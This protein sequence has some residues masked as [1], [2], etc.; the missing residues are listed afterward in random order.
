MDGPGDIYLP[1][2]DPWGVMTWAHTHFIKP[3]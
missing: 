1:E 2:G 3:P